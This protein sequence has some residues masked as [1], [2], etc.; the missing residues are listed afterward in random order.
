VVLNPVIARFQ[1]RGVTL[2]KDWETVKEEV[3]R[4]ALRAKFSQ[5]SA[6]T[7]LLR[8]TGSRLLI[9]ASGSDYYWGAG[10]DGNGQT[11]NGTEFG[12]TLERNFSPAI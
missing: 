11:P 1:A 2:R 9:E 7:H 4:V 10:A 12:S 3:M 8:A 5:H 6:L